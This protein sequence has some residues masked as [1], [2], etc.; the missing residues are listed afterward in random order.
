M[1]APDDGRATSTA[2]TITVPD[3]YDYA[4]AP[5]NLS[6]ALVTN[7]LARAYGYFRQGATNY[8]FDITVSGIGA[9]CTTWSTACSGRTRIAIT[10]TAGTRTGTQNATEIE[11]ALG[12]A[13]I[14]GVSRVGAVITIAGASGLGFGL[15]MST[16]ESQRGMWGRQ[17]TDF[18]GAPSTARNFGSAVNATFNVH[19]AAPSTAGRII[20]VYVLATSGARSGNLR[21]G[22]A[23]G[24][25][26]ALAPTAFSAGVEGTATRGGD[27]YLLALPEPMASASAANKW[28][29]GRTNTAAAILV[30]TRIHAAVVEGSSDPGR[31]DLTAA[32]QNVIDTTITNPA[33]AIYTAGAYTPTASLNF[34]V[35][36][37]VGFVYEL[38]TGGEY[39]GDGSLD[40]Y[41][42]DHNSDS[43]NGTPSTI[44]PTTLDGL[45]DTPR[46]PVPWPCNIVYLRQ[47]AAAVGADED[48]GFGFYDCTATL[49]TAYPMSPAPTLLTNGGV[50]R[51]SA[52]TGAGYKTHTLATPIAISSAVTR[53]GMFSTG[54]KI[55]GSIPADTITIRYTAPGTAVAWLAGWVDDGRTWD[56]FVVE[57]GGLGVNAQYLTTPGDM[58]FGDPDPV[59]PA[60]FD[61]NATDSTSSN[62]PRVAI[63]VTSTGFTT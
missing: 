8:A 15:P 16:D 10:L 37:A 28:I 17:R 2:I 12:V 24:P 51:I 30:E 49:G 19:L 61:T 31:G 42:G 14:T 7:R 41:I 35:Y 50:G 5:M 43:A 54:G 45:A 57:R 11:T 59:Y 6:R 62:H 18:G 55:N 56:D 25:A 63:R 26:Y 22:I 46:F 32:E 13:G 48:F 21:L 27:I 60:T 53:V 44:G 29:S 39:Y 20:G 38:P 9:N 34:A 4:V 47:A 33:T 23:N 58:P 3:S 52:I 40:T 36:M 1:S